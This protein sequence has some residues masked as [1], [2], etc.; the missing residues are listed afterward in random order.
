MC[1]ILFE[2]QMSCH[3]QKRRQVSDGIR[4]FWFV[5]FSEPI[6]DA[7]LSVSSYQVMAH[8]CVSVCVN[9]CVCV[10]ALE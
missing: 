4:L 7:G 3:H 6:I 2:F 10:C 9:V 1:I 8:L 5:S